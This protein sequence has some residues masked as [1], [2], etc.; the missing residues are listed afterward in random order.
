MNRVRNRSLQERWTFEREGGETTDRGLLFRVG[1]TE[2]ET[3]Y[4]EVVSQI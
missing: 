4:Q 1:F 2:L 3:R